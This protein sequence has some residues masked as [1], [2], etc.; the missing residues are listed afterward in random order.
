MTDWEK[1]CKGC[2]FYKIDNGS[3]F[4]YCHYF[5]DTGK[6]KGPLK[7]GKCGKK[8]TGRKV[9]KRVCPAA[10]NRKAKVELR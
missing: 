7:D 10:G 4:A 3:G 2:K 1:I 6:L 9:R 5:L 8:E